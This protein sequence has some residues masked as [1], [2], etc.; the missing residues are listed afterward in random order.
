MVAESKDWKLLYGRSMN[1]TYSELMEK[2]MEQ[3]EDLSKRLSRNVKDLDDVRQAMGSLKELRE[4]EIFIDSS[5]GPIEVVY[6]YVCVDRGY[7]Q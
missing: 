5:L 4:Q 1:S 3:I 7:M 6:V 2:I